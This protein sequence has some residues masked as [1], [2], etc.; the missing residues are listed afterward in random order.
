MHGTV[1]LEMVRGDTAV[2]NVEVFDPATGLA[3]DISAAVTMQFAAA[4]DYDAASPVT[5]LGLGTGVAITNGPAGEA[6]IVIPSADT[7]ALPNVKDRLVF[8]FQVE[9]PS[10][11]YT[12]VRGGLTVLPQVVG[13]P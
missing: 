3:I 13:G 4:Q 9:L 2:F 6:Q 1:E 12:P 5:L 7:E 8:D 11:R 10:R